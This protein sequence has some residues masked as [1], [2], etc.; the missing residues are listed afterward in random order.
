MT[1]EHPKKVNGNL[2]HYVLKARLITQDRTILTHRN[3]C[4]ERKASLIGRSI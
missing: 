1:W 2:T 4:N 3:Y